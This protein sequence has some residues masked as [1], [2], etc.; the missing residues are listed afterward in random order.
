M[1]QKRSESARERGIELY[2]QA[3]I[4]ITIS[5]TTGGGYNHD[6]GYRGEMEHESSPTAATRLAAEAAAAAARPPPRPS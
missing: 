6:G 4:I 3:T 5:I 1:R 2:I